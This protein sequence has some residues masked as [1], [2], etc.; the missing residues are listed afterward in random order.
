MMMLEILHQLVEACFV[1]AAAAA[2]AVVAAVSLSSSKTYQHAC[3]Y[4]C[5]QTQ[6]YILLPLMI[7]LHFPI[8]FAHRFLRR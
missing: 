1:L 7:I 5:I 3:N 4:V 2:A 6:A 8:L